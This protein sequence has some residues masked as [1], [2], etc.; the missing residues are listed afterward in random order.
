[1]AW[2]MV[3]VLASY[4][5]IGWNLGLGRHAAFVPLHGLNQY[6]RGLYSFNLIYVANF[7]IC[8]VSILLFYL[9]VFST[10]RKRVWLSEP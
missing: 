4:A 6:L 8:K 1:M 10:I 2:V 9:R 7:S 3:W 5:T